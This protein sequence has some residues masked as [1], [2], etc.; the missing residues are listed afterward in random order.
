MTAGVNEYR[1]TFRHQTDRAPAPVVIEW[2]IPLLDTVGKWHPLIAADRSLT[3]GWCTYIQSYATRSA[4]VYTLFSEAGENR[5]T[6]AL[7]D[8]IN[9]IS[10]RIQVEEDTAEIKCEV[11]LFD[12]PSEPISEYQVTLR[13]DNRQLPYHESLADI[14]DWWAAMEEYRPA[15]VP[16]SAFDPVYSTWY[17]YHQELTEE[18]IEQ[19][20]KWSKELGCDSVIVDDGWQTDDS[21]KGYQFCGDWEIA[22][23]K[24]PGFTDHVKRVQEMNMRYLLWFSVPYAGRESEAW[25]TFRDRVLPKAHA[26]ADCLDPRFPKVRQYLIDLYRKA[27]EDWGLDGLKLDFVDQ[28]TAEALSSSEEETHDMVSVPCAAD[29]LLSDM[30]ETLQKVRPDV[31]IEFRQ[32]YIGPAMRKYGNILRAQDCPNDALSNRVRTIDV[33][34]LAGNTAVHSDMI[35]WHREETVERVSQQ[36]WASLFAVPQISVR[37]NAIPPEHEKALQFFL[38]FWKNHRDCLVHGELQPLEPQLLYPVVIARSSKETIA[39]VY[40][41]GKVVQLPELNHPLYLINASADSKVYLD[42]ANLS[43]T[44]HY[45]IFDCTGSEVRT[46]SIQEA[47]PILTLPVPPSGLVEI[48]NG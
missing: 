13:I 7:S 26:N 9:P 41:S 4:P 43:K 46:D 10:T 28:F 38:R 32:R 40:Q 20:C 19:E 15:A 8:A 5:Q 44:I 25:K 33:R 37:G 42:T 17:S 21:N 1:F 2:K 36:L 18:E 11:V 16:E 35:M 27:V 14:S 23:S 30:S 39:A 48:R 22:T 3:S 24:F 29:R 31:L 34:L 47:G 45:K 12:A 6:F